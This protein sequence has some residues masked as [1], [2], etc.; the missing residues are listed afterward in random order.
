MIRKILRMLG[1][2]TLFG[3]WT[4]IRS[5]RG[6]LYRYALVDRVTHVDIAIQTPKSPRGT[7]DDD[8]HLT[9]KLPLNSYSDIKKIC[10]HAGKEPKNIEKAMRALKEYVEL[11]D[12]WLET[13]KSITQQI[14]EMKN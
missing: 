3:G 1:H 2:E 10:F 5:S 12:T 6:K 8:S 9:H 7:E 14:Q 13:G 11:Y 4:D